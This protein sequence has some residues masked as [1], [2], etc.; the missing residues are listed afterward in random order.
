MTPQQFN[1]HMAG[2]NFFSPKGSEEHYY[3]CVLKHK[4]PDHMAVYERWRN[5][6]L[7]GAPCPLPAFDDSRLQFHD[8]LFQQAVE[9]SRPMPE[10]FVPDY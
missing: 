2:Y 6:H 7:V 4:S 9:A 3:V 8:R 5:Y 10:Q 1:N